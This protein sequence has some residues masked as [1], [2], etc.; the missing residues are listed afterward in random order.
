[1]PQYFVTKPDYLVDK[2]RGFHTV[3]PNKES[4]MEVDLLPSNPEDAEVLRTALKTRQQ[5][6]ASLRTRYRVVIADTEADAAVL[7][8][9]LGL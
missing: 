4:E 1:M 5:K 2:S 7:A 3:V 8:K 9:Q 6:A